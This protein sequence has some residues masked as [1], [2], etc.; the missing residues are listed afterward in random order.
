VYESWT[1]PGAINF[2]ITGAKKIPASTMKIPIKDKKLK[3][4]NTSATAFECP[5]F[6]RVLEKTGTNEIL[7]IPSENSLRTISTGRKAIK[8]ASLWED[9]PKYMAM[10]AS[11]TTPS[12]RL[13]KVRMLINA[14]FFRIFITTFP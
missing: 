6:S 14:V 7:K 8:N 2:I 5:S 4:E 1:N 11:L 13:P 10:R 9:V 3:K 12:I